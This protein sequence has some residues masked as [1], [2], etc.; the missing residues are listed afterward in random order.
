MKDL[1]DTI[2]LDPKGRE[3]MSLYVGAGYGEQYW[4]VPQTLF[5][6]SAHVSSHILFILY[7]HPSSHTPQS[8]QFHSP[9]TTP[10]FTHSLNTLSYSLSQPLLTNSNKPLSTPLFVVYIV[11]TKGAFGIK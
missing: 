1:Y 5:T 4:Y 3:T 10:F 11:C 7:E 8:T 6:L 2:N 9:L